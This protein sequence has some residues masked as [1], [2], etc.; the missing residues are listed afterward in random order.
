MFIE[1]GSSYK[2]LLRI[3]YSSGH[4]DTLTR[5]VATV[6]TLPVEVFPGEQAG[7]FLVDLLFHQ[8]VFCQITNSDFS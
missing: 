5:I 1:P 3:Y 7:L 6:P 8:I 4:H 2:I